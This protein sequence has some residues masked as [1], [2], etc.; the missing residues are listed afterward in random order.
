V[1][2]N[3]IAQGYRRHPDKFRLRALCDIDAAR[4]ASVAD[5]FSILRRT[6]SFDEL[7]RIDGSTLPTFARRQPS[8]SSRSSPHSR[9][10]R[11]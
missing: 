5:E 1:G 4:L 9:P 6:T 11:K 2:R 8:T 3:H 10:A 7:L